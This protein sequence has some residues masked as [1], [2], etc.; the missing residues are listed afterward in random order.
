[1]PKIQKISEIPPRLSFTEFDILSSF[2]KSFEQ[3]KLGRLYDSFPFSSFC[4]SLGLTDHPLGRRSY[5]SAEGKVAL[6]LLKSY[7]GLS[8]ADL[9][10]HLNGNIHFQLFCGIW[11]DP[12]HPLTNAKLISSIRCQLAPLLD[13]DSAQHV[14]AT[15]WKPYLDNLH[16]CMTDATCYESFIRYPT[17]VKLLWESID[18]LYRHMSKI[19]KYLHIR[20][21]RNKYPEVKSA[22]LTY[23]KKRKR[24]TSTTRM[25]TRRLLHLLEKLLEQIH[26]LISSHRGSIQ[27][28]SDFLRRLNVITRVLDQQQRI[29]EGQKVSNRIVSIDKHY[30]RPIVRGKENKPVEFGAK[31]NTIQVDGL[32]FIQHISFDAFN[33]GTLLKDCVSLHH[34]LFGKRV[35]S[36]AADAIYATNANRKFCSSRSIMTSFVRKGRAAKDEP[37]RKV[38]RAELSRER[39]TRLEGSYGTHKEH[40][41]L[42]KVK[43]RREPTE[44]L[45]IFFAIH[46]SNAVLIANKRRTKQQQEYKEAS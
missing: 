7:T 19:C 36:L 4:H 10:A 17:S 15:H 42:R 28:S 9:L 38:L 32:S 22:Y 37:L 18:Q 11:I 46:T 5:F 20:R 43:A 33:E 31:V 41:G 8:D 16:V 2:R 39:A 12:E 3:S 30:I 27:P 23:S 26:E 21:P 25:L 34:R 14:L 40:Y 24:K 45:W 35:R 13:I 44:I 6:M 1:M 29:F